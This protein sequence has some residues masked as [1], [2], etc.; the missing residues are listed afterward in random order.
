[1]GESKIILE[2]DTK[3]E[4]TSF[5][6]NIRYLYDVFQS[7]TEETI[8]IRSNEY[9]RPFVVQGFGNQDFTYLIMPMNR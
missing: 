5:N 6:C 3:G 8:V 1:V 4:E 9:N 7:I 2:V